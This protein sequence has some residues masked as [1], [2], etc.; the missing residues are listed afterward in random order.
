LFISFK[1]EDQLVSQLQK[2]K[3]E[4]NIVLYMQF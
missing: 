4:S 3:S 2:K 1:A